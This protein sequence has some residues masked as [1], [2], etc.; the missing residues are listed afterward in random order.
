MANNAALEMG[1]VSVVK[2]AVVGRRVRRREVWEVVGFAED[3]LNRPRIKTRTPRLNHMLCAWPHASGRRWPP[4]LYIQYASFIF[5][6]QHQV[7]YAFKERED[8]LN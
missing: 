8:T 3:A 2:S 7:K 5:A 1:G 4:F 6:L